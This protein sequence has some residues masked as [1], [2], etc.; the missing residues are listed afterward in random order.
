MDHVVVVGGGLAGHR[1]VQALA[2]GFEGTV[3]LIT[4]E[5][6]KP[7]DRPPLSK[8]VLTGK[9][10]PDATGFKC[11]ELDVEWTLATAAERLDPSDKTVG[12]A[13]GEEIAYDG[14]I[15]ATGRRAREWPELPDL[16][17]FFMLRS[18]DDARRLKQAISQCSRV[19]IVGAGFIGCEVAASLKANGVAEVTLIDIADEPL[20]PVGP[21]AGAFARRIHEAEGVSF[22]LGATVTGFD[23][24]G[25]HVRAVCFE[26][27]DEVEADLVLLALG[28]VPNTEWLE[29]SGVELLKGAVVCDEHLFARGAEDVVAAGDVAA[30]PHPH[31]ADEHGLAAIEHWTTSRE[32]AKAAALNLVAAPDDRSRFVTVPSFWSDQ[33]DVKIKSAGL[34]QAADRLDV[35]EEDFE[36]RR[37]VVEAKRGDE[38]VGAVVFNRNKTFADYQRKL[39]SALEH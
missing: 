37:L 39:K 33:Y 25:G 1:A 2:R 20:T 22:R 9:V 36:Q 7:Y 16:G 28:S 5:D 27:G 23:G 13:D 29:G 4:D 6:H 30:W 3:T 32:L 34:L 21:A 35:V 17:G 24:V 10:E 31:V 26:G 12:L 38:L 14:L 19:A 18:L 8:Q 11:D 15:I